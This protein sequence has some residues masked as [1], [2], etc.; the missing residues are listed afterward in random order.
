MRCRGRPDGVCHAPSNRS[1]R[2]DFLGVPRE[3]TIQAK[4][5]D[6]LGFPRRELGTIDLTHAGSG[7]LVKIEWWEPS[8]IARH[9]SKSCGGSSERTRSSHTRLSFSSTNTTAAS[10]APWRPQP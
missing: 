6:L 9:L 8:W 3:C 7:A 10:M 5:P 2:D 1:L 4:N